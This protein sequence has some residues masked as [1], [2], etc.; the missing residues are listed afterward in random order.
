MSFECQIIQ[1]PGKRAQSSLKNCVYCVWIKKV[2]LK[3][4][5]YNLS[6]TFS[7]LS[8]ILDI[9]TLQQPNNS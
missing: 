1:A 9:Q 6:K 4:S 7:V 3:I 2:D 5:G 8:E